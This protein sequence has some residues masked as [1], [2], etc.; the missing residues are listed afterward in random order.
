MDKVSVLFNLRKI[1][2]TIRIVWE[3]S[4]LWM[5]INITLTFLQGVIPLAVFILIKFLVDMISQT[6]TSRPGHF[7]TV[8]L[9]VAATGSVYLIQAIFQSIGDAV[10]NHQS[11]MVTD[12]VFDR[13]H[14]KSAQL[15]Y[16][17]FE[18]PAYHNLLHRVQQD[19]AYR[20][21][22]M[23]DE[24]VAI[25]QNAVSITCIIGL[26][27]LIHWSMVLILI[28]IT[29][30]GLIVKLNHAKKMH[31]WHFQ[32]AENYRRAEY[33][34][35]LLTS[36]ES[37][38]ELR[39]YSL[40][41][42][43]IKRFKKT[44]DALRKERFD[45]YGHQIKTAAIS[46]ALV[47][48]TIS[49]MLIFLTR[50]AVAGRITVGD[51]AMYF[52]ALYRGVGFLTG[53]LNALSQLYED[54][55]F[56][57]QL[58]EF[59]RIPSQK[60]LIHAPIRSLPGG[61][62]HDI[63][64]E[65]VSF[66]YP[67]SKRHVIKNINL[68]IPAGKTVALVGKSGSGKTTLVKLLCRLY[69]PDSGKI[70]A[71]GINIQTIDPRQWHRQLSIVFQDPVHYQ[72]SAKENIWI[73]DPESDVS[74]DKIME[75]AGQTGIHE[76]L[77]N[78]PDQYDTMLG[79][80]FTNSEQLSAGEWQRIALARSFFHNTPIMIFDEPTRAMD[81]EAEYQLFRQLKS[82]KASKTIVLISHRFSTVREADIIY[83][84]ENQ[85]VIETGSHWE[86][87][88]LNGRYAHLYHLQTKTGGD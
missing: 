84:I 34:H 15:D 1:A 60:P 80:L 67:G 32:Q 25:L 38:K 12:Y 8:A 57:E 65:N 54:S 62:T 71:N 47:A 70:T 64:F 78:L 69:E 56:L 35:Q 21:G 83:M 23:V 27:S 33:Y 17:Y 72:L 5:L 30:P 53:F 81:A 59:F 77:Q 85:K 88:R 29:I 16:A 44:R 7:T 55:L 45:I 87:L 2:E 14:L 4:K 20:P 42:L 22:S 18:N 74:M 52:L 75:V 39:I 40:Y 49:G 19:A 61:T 9:I 37:A 50:Q 41:E 11:D 36:T 28:I 10:K 79:H 3:G 82:F 76:V 48:I 43:F 86:L 58:L 66:S 24:L 46:H 31:T 63:K 51:L 68:H 73:G 26:F 6:I 13:I